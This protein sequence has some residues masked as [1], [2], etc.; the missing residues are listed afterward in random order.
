MGGGDLNMKKSWHP[1][2]LVNQERV[3]KAE[4]AVNEEK[5]KVSQLRKER[6]EE[7]QLAELQ[8][9]QE[10][11]TGRK[12]VE[13]LDWMYAAPG[14][15][16]GA[17]GGARL[18]EKEMEDYLLGKKRVDEVLAQSDKNVGNLHKDFIAIQ[19]ANTARDTAAKIREDPLLAIKRQEIASIEALKNR[20]EVRKKLREMQKAKEMD[21]RGETKEERKDRRRAE[22]EERRA[23]RDEKG[24]SRDRD[25]DRH[26]RRHSDD[27]Y[28]DRSRERSYDRD[29]SP[30][31]SRDDRDRYRDDDSKRRNDRSESRGHHHEHRNGHTEKAEIKP[32][33]SRPSA[34]DLADRPTSSRYSPPTTSHVNG[35]GSGGANGN[36][37]GKNKL[38]EM[39]AARLA[40][41]SQSADQLYSSRTQV[42][43]QRAEQEKREAE[44]EERLRSKYGQ[45]DVRGG[46]FKERSN[47]NLSEALGRR[48]GKGLVSLD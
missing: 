19:S 18:G 20:P 9:M 3:W 16:G 21:E 47:M 14:N 33:P 48:A 39:R 10:A 34:M 12:R 45:E 29:R 32:H 23:K 4:K 42:L 36:G 22:K 30:R 8:R 24:K 15:E 6:E 13:R 5:K 17:L 25:D 40:A 35:S 46:F 38:D 11:S 26:R 41:M 7:R 27:R 43:S 31:R 2:L 44:R 1:V 28:R 37:Q